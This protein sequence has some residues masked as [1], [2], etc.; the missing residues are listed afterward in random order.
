MS[1]T[2]E[3]GCVDRQDQQL[4]SYPILRRYAKGY[5]KIFYVLDMAV[6]NAYML[7]A[8]KTGKRGSYTDWKVDL[9][10]EIIAETALPRYQRRG[11]QPVRLSPH[12]P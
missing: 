8:K 3:W 9:S 10:E 6:Y 2:E 12:A 1:T 4:V 5:K 11:K 7:H